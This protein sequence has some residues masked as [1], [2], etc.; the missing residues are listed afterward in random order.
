MA[1]ARNEDELTQDVQQGTLMHFHRRSNHS[2]YDTIYC[3]SNDSAHGKHIT[4]ETRATCLACAQGNQTK[5]P[6][7]RKA[8]A[9]TC[10]SMS[11]ED[12]FALHWRVPWLLATDSTVVMWLICW[13]SQKLLPSFFLQIANTLR[14]KVLT[15]HGFFKRQFKFRIHVLRKDG[16]GD[17]CTLDLFCKDTGIVR[18]F[19]QTKSQS[20]NGKVDRMHR[21]IMNMVWRMVFACVLP[22]SFWDDASK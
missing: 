13:A 15:L 10:R 22:L 20:R 12:S 16:G 18:H 9:K 3:M 7:S 11:S 19:G 4:D 17:Y 6:Q 1:L 2:N 5:N 14:L 8:L 21:T